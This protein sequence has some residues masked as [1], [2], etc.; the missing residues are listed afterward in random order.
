MERAINYK[1]FIPDLFAHC[2]RCAS[3]HSRPIAAA[4]VFSVSVETHVAVSVHACTIFGTD[5]TVGGSVPLV[6]S[7]RVEVEAVSSQKHAG[8]DG[9]GR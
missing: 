2:I 4:V 7:F 8:V 5:E 9:L 1:P 6:S 3:L